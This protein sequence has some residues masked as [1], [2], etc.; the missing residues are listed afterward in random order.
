MVFLDFLGKNRYFLAW[1]MLLVGCVV[2][3]ALY[4]MRDSVEY[5]LKIVL[6]LWIASWVLLYLDKRVRSENS[7]KRD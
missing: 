5:L 2:G 4:F 1:C 3:F 6:P 7:R